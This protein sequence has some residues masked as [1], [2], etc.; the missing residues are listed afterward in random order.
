[1]SI[2]RAFTQEGISNSQLETY[3][4]LYDNLKMVMKLGFVLFFKI[5]L[6]TCKSILLV[7]EFY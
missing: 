5:D 4:R 7:K 6:I 3:S 1:M 2:Q